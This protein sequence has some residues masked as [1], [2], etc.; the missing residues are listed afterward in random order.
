MK[1]LISLQKRIFIQQ[2]TTG[3]SDKYQRTVF[4]L[5]F[6]ML[7]VSTAQVLSQYELHNSY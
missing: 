1:H 7:N 5:R 3:K 4:F 6:W 2:S